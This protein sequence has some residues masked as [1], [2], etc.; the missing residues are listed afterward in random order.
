[1][2]TKLT[3][4]FSRSSQITNFGITPKGAAGGGGGGMRVTSSKVK[5]L[6]SPTCEFVGST[7][8]QRSTISSFSPLPRHLP[9][10]DDDSWP[11]FYLFIRTS[12][13]ATWVW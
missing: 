2:H 4:S 7:F 11:S 13:T 9:L 3:R 6:I 10:Q 1:M 12:T 8:Y 5:A